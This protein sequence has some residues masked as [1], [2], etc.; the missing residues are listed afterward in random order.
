MTKQS[1]GLPLVGVVRD[2]LN[3]EIINNREGGGIRNAC[4]RIQ[5]NARHGHMTLLKFANHIIS[6]HQ[7]R[8]CLLPSRTWCT[9]S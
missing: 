3:G 5:D 7:Q 4:T 1:V 9:S 2:T 6:L 8:L